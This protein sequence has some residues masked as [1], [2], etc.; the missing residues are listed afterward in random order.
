M[1]TEDEKEL[2]NKKI[3]NNNDEEY[4]YDEDEDEDEEYEDEEENNEEL[5]NDN[6][7]KNNKKIFDLK[8]KNHR[9]GA[10][11][12]LGVFAAGGFYYVK[13]KN[14]NINYEPEETSNIV[15]DSNNTNKPLIQK[16]NKD[17][18]DIKDNKDINEN[19]LK[20]D[21]NIELLD[22]DN[23]NDS[24]NK[25]NIDTKDLPKLKKPSD[26]IQSNSEERIKTLEEK[27][28]SIEENSSKVEELSKRVSELEKKV[29]L[30][31]KTDSLI[32]D[33]V[34][35]RKEMEKNKEEQLIKDKIAKEGNV[36]ID[37]PDFSTGKSRLIGF[38][39]LPISNDPSIILLSDVNNNIVAV[40]KDTGFNYKGKVLKIE[41]VSEDGK[42]INFGNN[43][44]V[45]TTLGF[46]G[47]K[48]QNVKINDNKVE[49]KNTIKKEKQKPNFQELNNIRGVAITKDYNDGK[50][51]VTVEDK[52]NNS[53]M[54]SLREG[55]YFK[56]YG[57]IKK[58]DDSGNIYFS[59]GKIN[60]SK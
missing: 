29:E 15:N 45:D 12:A 42:I 20:G 39:I 60:F 18:K 2:E 13:N 14:N 5:K 44:F 41:E 53:E 43:L 4:D 9:I 55:E 52:N 30:I 34:N 31:E 40:S 25:A 50:Y 17:I 6:K 59:K 24:L 37:V 33:I 38:K 36:N 16:D 26:N 46:G 21:N 27:L 56:N 28:N 8:N 48:N 35:E 32:Q 54:T 11:V 22:T 7:L 51:T 47:T 10:L 1:N 58:I 3:L 49:I 57:K 19:T 23:I